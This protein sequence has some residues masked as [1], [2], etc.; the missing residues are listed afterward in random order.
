MTSSNDEFGGPWPRQKLDVLRAFLNAYT[1]AL[2]N[3][4]IRLI[5]IVDNI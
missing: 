4:P 5:Y 2:M 3:Q 1:T